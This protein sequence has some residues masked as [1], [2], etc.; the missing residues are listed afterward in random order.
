MAVHA[1]KHAARTP[2][3]LMAAGSSEIIANEEW[4]L[5]HLPGSAHGHRITE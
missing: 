4:A 5:P 3:R 2:V 1:Y